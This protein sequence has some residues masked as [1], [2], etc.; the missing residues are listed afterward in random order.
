MKLQITELRKLNLNTI[1]SDNYTVLYQTNDEGRELLVKENEQYRWFEYGG[2]SIQSIMS[3]A[4]PEQLVSPVSQ[5]LLLFVTVFNKP[6]KVLNLGLG[7][8][9]IERAL[10]AIPD[11][12]VTSVESS[13]PII[14][15]SVKYFDLPSES[16]IVFEK[17]ELYIQKSKIVY[18]VV[19]CDL[20][21]GESNPNFLFNNHF[22]EHLNR[23][24]LQTSLIMLNIQFDSE[25]V[26][27]DTLLKIKKCF[28]YLALFEFDDYSNI[29][30]MASNNELACKQ[31]LKTNLSN[32]EYIDLTSLENVIE[33]MHYIYQ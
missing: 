5:S 15:M 31:T 3:K 18:D 16:D 30:V 10:S 26:L 13:Q 28:P 2:N 19:L 14:N 25:K 29:V 1:T 7:G 22:Y 12:A 8:G 4:K 33:K 32:Y 24:T 11:I 27:L 6:L 9:T 23:I 20:F 21:I 17:A